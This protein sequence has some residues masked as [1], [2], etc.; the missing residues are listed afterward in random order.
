MAKGWYVVHTYSGYE[1]KA[2]EALE[3]RMKQEGMETYFEEILVPTETV[4]AVV[5]GQRKT[6]QRKIYPG[7][8]IVH[9]ELNDETWHLVKDTPKIMGFA[10]NSK[11]PKPMSEKEVASLMR[12][13]HEG[14][15]KVKPK[16]DYSEGDLLKIIDGPFSGFTGT[17]DEIKP[18]KRKLRVLVSIFGRSTPVELEFSQVEKA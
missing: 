4:V 14:A 3:S 18:D 16:I 17:I 8:I 11:N 1:L 7:Y 6:S 9:M 2:K 15:S 5:K 13:I 12:Q 10:G